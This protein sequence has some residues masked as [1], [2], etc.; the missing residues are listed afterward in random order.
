MI[1][2]AASGHGYRFQLAFSLIILK[3]NYDF[4]F[5]CSSR[6]LSEPGEVPSFIT[7]LD[8]LRRAVEKGHVEDLDRFD[9]DAKDYVEA[10][11]HEVSYYCIRLPFLHL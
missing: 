6:F 7:A 3:S 4:L 2:P 5:V 10:D 1:C 9:L 11:D 8:E